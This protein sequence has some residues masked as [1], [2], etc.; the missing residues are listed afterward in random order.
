M[1]HT[2]SPDLSS[3]ITVLFTFDPMINTDS[4]FVVC[5]ESGTVLPLHSAYI[6]DLS[7]AP[8]ESYGDDSLTIEYAETNGKPLIQELGL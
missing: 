4:L 2:S 8:V 6:V 3:R 7:D 5:T 1:L